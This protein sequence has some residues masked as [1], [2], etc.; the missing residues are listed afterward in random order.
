[1][2]AGSAISIVLRTARTRTIMIQFTLL[3]G[4]LSSVKLLYMLQIQAEQIYRWRIQAN[5][6]ELIII[7]WK[8]MTLNKK[9]ATAWVM[10]VKPRVSDPGE[11]LF[12]LEWSK[13]LSK[14]KLTINILARYANSGEVKGSGLYTEDWRDTQLLMCFQKVKM[15]LLVQ[16]RLG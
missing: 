11:I 6:W 15:S 8:K 4:Q 7:F 2:V 1:M 5:Q 9:D 3:L 12:L 13:V 14:W 16:D 10:S